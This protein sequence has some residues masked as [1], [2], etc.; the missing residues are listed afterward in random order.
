MFS[1]VTFNRDVVVRNRDS[2]T[3]TLAV[4][5]LIASIHPSSGCVSNARFPVL[6]AM[7]ILRL[8][9]SANGNGTSAINSE[10]GRLSSRIASAERFAVRITVLA[11][12]CRAACPMLDSNLPSARAGFVRPRRPLRTNLLWR[13]AS[14]Y[15][16]GDVKMLRS[17]VRYREVFECPGPSPTACKPRCTPNTTEN[18]Q[19]FPRGGGTIARNGAPAL[20]RN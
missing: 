7:P 18:D 13:P 5:A 19:S 12:P 17:Y 9:S 11:R 1:G 3:A 15:L 14:R 20:H 4:A 2:R 6:P 8:T 16:A 10:S